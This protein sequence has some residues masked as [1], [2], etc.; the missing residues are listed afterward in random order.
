MVNTM[1]ILLI[2]FSGEPLAVL[3]S[4]LVGQLDYHISTTRDQGNIAQQWVTKVHT[5]GPSYVV[6]DRRGGDVWK[7]WWCKGAPL[8]G[9]G[10]A[11]SENH[12]TAPPALDQ[13]LTVHLQSTSDLY[14]SVFSTSCHLYRRTGNKIVLPPTHRPPLVKKTSVVAAHWSVTDNWLSNNSISC[15][16]RP[17]ETDKCSSN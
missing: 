2:S 15:F 7:R 1:M 14:S 11:L 5:F 10:C 3:K 13:L 4:Y 9:A 16:V 17:S 6:G 8:P 12:R